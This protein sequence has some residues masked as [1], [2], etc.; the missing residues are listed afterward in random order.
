MT[1]ML[2]LHAGY[3]VSY[4]TDA[5][6][7]GG[8]D[9]YLSAS[10]KH[11]EPPGYWTGRGAEAL[12]LAGEVDAQV[13]R[14]LYHHGIRPG[15]E[16]LDVRQQ[17]SDYAGMRES[18]ED[19]IEAL[20]VERVAELGGPE[21]VTE[22]EMAEIRLMVAGRQRN[23]VT[24]FDFTLSTAKSISVA[25]ASYQATA[26]AARAAGDETEAR[27]CADMVRAIEDAVRAGA[28]QV[29]RSAERQ[30]GYVRTGH[31]GQGQG[32]WRDA[33]GLTAAVF[34]QHTSR[35]GDPQLHA[36]IAILNRAQRADGADDKWRTLDSRSLH[37]ERLGIAARAGMVVEQRLLAAGF[38]LVQREDGN[39]REIEGV[40]P[41]TMRAFS[42]RRTA[43]TPAIKRLVDE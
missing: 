5:V 34:L 38:S 9:Y 19:R 27:R 1:V 28:E 6:G 8:T 16:P 36:H 22:R 41:A 26:E 30:A 42:A 3:D 40:S 18:L 25:A 13:M 21:Y 2:S 12:G 11:G 24:F 7:T 17:P 35:D 29:V 23:S 43:I 10:G 33:A 15:G 4:L 14:A 31:H 39:G 20:I 37:R 32:Q